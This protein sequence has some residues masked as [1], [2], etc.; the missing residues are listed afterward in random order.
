[1]P[2]NHGWTRTRHLAVPVWA[3]APV[4]AVDGNFARGVAPRREALVLELV[5]ML[6]G[7]LGVDDPDLHGGPT[8]P[9]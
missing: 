3:S 9:R 6:L 7:V 8:P 5:L 4:R 2:V 1:M